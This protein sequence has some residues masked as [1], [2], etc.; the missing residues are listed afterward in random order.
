MAQREFSSRVETR[1]F[2]I[3]DQSSIDMLPQLRTLVFRIRKEFQEPFMLITTSWELVL[4]HVFSYLS[5]LH[6]ASQTDV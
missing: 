1:M 3:V 4:G 6:E 2:T 5:S